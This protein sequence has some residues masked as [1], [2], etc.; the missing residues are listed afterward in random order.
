MIPSG[1][2]SG[3]PSASGTPEPAASPPMQVGLGE[4]TSTLAPD[5]NTMGADEVAIMAEVDTSAQQDPGEK[6]PEVVEKR[7]SPSLAQPISTPAPPPTLEATRIGTSEVLPPIL[8]TA[9]DWAGAGWTEE[10]EDALKGSSI[11]EEHRAL[12][13]SALQGYR[14]TGSGIHEVFKNLVAG[15]EVRFLHIQFAY[16]SCLFYEFCPR[17]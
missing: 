13:G 4:A 6:L 2:S 5:V 1:S 15:F 7:L 17:T 12:I 10:M 16:L 11:K 8:P 3:L 14:S 9:Q